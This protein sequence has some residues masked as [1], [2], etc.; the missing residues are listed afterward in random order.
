MGRRAGVGDS[1]QRGRLGA[2]NLR[3]AI[4]E[5]NPQGVSAITISN[6]PNRI[7]AELES[8]AVREGISVQDLLRRRLEQTYP[9]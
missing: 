8:D 3:K 4:H 7:L 2:S 1:F 9:S 5:S 6:I